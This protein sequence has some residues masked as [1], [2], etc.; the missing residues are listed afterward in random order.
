MWCA[1]P[2]CFREA[3][4][5]CV[6]CGRQYCAGHC[7]PWVYS[8]GDGLYECAL[9]ERHLTPGQVRAETPPD[10]LASVGAVGFFLVAVAV[11]TAMDV[12]AKGPGIIVLSVFALAFVFM[13]RCVSH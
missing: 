13:A 10:L 12:A 4:A 1:Y 5:R 3:A 7:S 8:A 2:R 6:T 11:G 9:C